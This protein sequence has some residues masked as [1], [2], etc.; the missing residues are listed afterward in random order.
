M[1]SW[2]A[3][4]KMNTLAIQGRSNRLFTRGQDKT[5]Q[6]QK[7]CKKAEKYTCKTGKICQVGLH[8]WGQDK[9][10]ARSCSSC[11]STHHHHITSM[12]RR[13]WWLSL[14]A[15][16]WIMRQWLNPTPS[17]PPCEYHIFITYNSLSAKCGILWIQL[18]YLYLKKIRPQN[19]KLMPKFRNYSF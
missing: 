10:K 11:G 17:Y 19:L 1:L 3:D 15:R 7:Q 9:R 16:F 2:N 18:W 6:I 8:S 4:E 13:C 12:W 5:E 14:F